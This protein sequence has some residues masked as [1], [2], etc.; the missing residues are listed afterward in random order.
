MLLAVVGA[1]LLCAVLVLVWTLKA[2]R[3]VY[4]GPP[5]VRLSTTVVW[6]G[7]QTWLNTDRFLHGK[8]QRLHKWAC[9][10]NY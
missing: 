5:V 8:P 7:A 6:C 1:V 9:K 3:P 2:P 4:P 10:R